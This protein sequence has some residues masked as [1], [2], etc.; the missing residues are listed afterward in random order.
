MSDRNQTEDADGD[1]KLDETRGDHPSGIIE[2]MTVEDVERLEP[3]V[4]VVGFGS[5]EPHG[6]HLPYGT[7]VFQT[8]AVCRRAVERAN[9]KGARVLK[10]P[11]LPIGNNVNF[12]AFP[13]A[14]RIGVRTL[15]DIALDMIEALEAEGIRKIL[16]VNGHGGNPA[17]LRAALR[18]HADRHPPGEGAFVCLTSTT[19]AI[20]DEIEDELEHPSVHGGESESSRMLH[21]REDLVREDEFDE[22]E[23]RE[24]T[25]E[26]LEGDQVYFVPRWDAYHPEVGGGETRESSAAKGEALVDG[27]ADWLAE[28]LVELDAADVD[29]LFPYSSG[30]RE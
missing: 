6:P 17:A 10:Y 18:E 23:I 9:E 12:K 2:E 8:K 15:M 25:I 22:F 1:A 11:T 28:F 5:T 16:F 14:C 26:G 3:E 27:A 19:D 7:D 20:P 13:F 21:L 24:P 4:V 29:E 30:A